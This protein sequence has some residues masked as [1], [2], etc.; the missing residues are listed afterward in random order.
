MTGIYFSIPGI[1]GMIE[2]YSNILEIGN[3]RKLI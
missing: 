1:E 3:A 2:I